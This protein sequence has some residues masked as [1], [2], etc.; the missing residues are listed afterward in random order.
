[1]NEDTNR[2]RWACVQEVMRR[3]HY[4]GRVFTAA[5]LPA[6]IMT[7]EELYQAMGHRKRE[8]LAN[9]AGLC[10]A[11]MHLTRPQDGLHEFPISCNS[12]GMLARY[13][14]H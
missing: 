5:D 7:K 14:S 13:G 8:R 2:R 11:V 6:E 3:E 9:L 12:K 10:Y 4:T 1:M